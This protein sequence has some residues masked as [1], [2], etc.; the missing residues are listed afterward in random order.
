MTL[1]PFLLL[2]GLLTVLPVLLHPTLPLGGSELTQTAVLVVVG[3]IAAE[4][5]E[6]FSRRR[7]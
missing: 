3:F 6:I 5:I 4:A 2:G 7:K 1:T